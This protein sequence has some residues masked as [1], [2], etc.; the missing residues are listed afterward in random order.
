[1]VLQRSVRNSEFNADRGIFFEIPVKFV[2][3]QPSHKGR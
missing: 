3:E 2:F 1:M